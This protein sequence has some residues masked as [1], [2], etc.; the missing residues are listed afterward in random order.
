MNRPLR[1]TWH[2]TTPVAGLTHP[3]HLDALVAYAVTEEA[4]R[5]GECDPKASVRSLSDNLPLGKAVGDGGLWCWQSSALQGHTK[6]HARRMWTSKNNFYDLC[7]R[8]RDQ[9]IVGKFDLPMKRFSMK[10]DDAHMKQ[11]FQFFPVRY[12]DTFTAWCIGDEDRL[13]ELLA[14]ESGFITRIGARK[15][16]GLGI[17]H[18]FEIARD[19]AALERWQQRMLPWPIDGAVPV[20]AAH[21]PPYWAP[22]NRHA[23][24]WIA[25]ALML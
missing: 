20:M 23:K 3:I 6:V 12:I 4:L 2:L 8:I 10:L 1:L 16:N 19:D 18:S 5:S 11:N 17:V 15:R 22:E 24:S 14:P 21:K 25:P 9:Q 13:L 7:R